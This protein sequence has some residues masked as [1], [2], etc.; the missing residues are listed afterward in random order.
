MNLPKLKH[1]G[2]T[3]EDGKHWEGQRYPEAA[4]MPWDGQ[5]PLLVG[6]RS[7]TLG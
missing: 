7:V 3:I 2:C 1:T 6:E 4:R 5:V